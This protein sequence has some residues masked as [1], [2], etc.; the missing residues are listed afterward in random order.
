MGLAFC[1][2]L[3]SHCP[4]FRRHP[5]YHGLLANAAQRFGLTISLKKTE[6]LLQPKPG[7]TY[8]PL[9]V[10]VNGSAFKSVEKFK[11]LKVYYHKTLF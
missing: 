10:K 11:Y 1:R 2:R 8:T 9:T 4:F 6:D 7:A 5:V 3:C